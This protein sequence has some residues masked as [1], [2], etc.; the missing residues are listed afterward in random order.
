MSKAFAYKA[1]FGKIPTPQTAGYFCKA[2]DEA[3]L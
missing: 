3:L 2:F 1:N